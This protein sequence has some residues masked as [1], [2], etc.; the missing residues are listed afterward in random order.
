MPERVRDL[1]FLFN[2]DGRRYA[3]EVCSPRSEPAPLSAGPFDV[4]ITADV[5]RDFD[6]Y[7][8]EEP[9]KVVGHIVQ[10]VR[11]LLPDSI[12]L[13]EWEA[14]TGSVYR[15]VCAHRRQAMIDD[16]NSELNEMRGGC[17]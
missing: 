13:V 10:F 16:W 5:P 2:A 17:D 7:D 4:H 15:W 3:V 9:E 6:D 12:P 8:D 11:S 14:F 1:Q